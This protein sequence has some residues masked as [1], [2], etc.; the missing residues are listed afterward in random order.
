M[1]GPPPAC[2][3]ICAS[4][5]L[6]TPE[7]RLPS[8]C[9]TP[10][11]AFQPPGLADIPDVTTAPDGLRLEP[12]GSG[13]GLRDVRSPGFK[14]ATNIIYACGSDA[15]GSPGPHQGQSDREICTGN[16]F[17]WNMVRHGDSLPLT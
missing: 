11:A 16:F 9:P 15:G 7:L 3:W 4:W 14:P 17:N 13:L 6:G 1:Y 2:K 12:R 8:M 5:S 10:G